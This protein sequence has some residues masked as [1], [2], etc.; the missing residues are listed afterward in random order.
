MKREQV[1]LGWIDIPIAYPTFTNKNKVKICDNII[2]TLLHYI[3]KEL[4]PTINRITFLEEVLDSTLETNVDLEL[5]EVA[6]VIHDCK[7]RLNDA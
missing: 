6:Q 4:D 3:D 7:K 2:D 5:Y 1:E